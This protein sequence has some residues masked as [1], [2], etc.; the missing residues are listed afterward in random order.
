MA[1][2]QRSYCKGIQSLSDLNV[3]SEPMDLPRGFK[4]LNTKM[5][6]RQKEAEFEGQER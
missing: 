3:F 2:A 6:L 4:A 5:V 1:K